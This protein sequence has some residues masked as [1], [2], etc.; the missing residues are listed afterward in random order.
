[1]PYFS[2]IKKSTIAADESRTGAAE[3]SRMEAED[4]TGGMQI[5]ERSYLKSAR[6]VKEGRV[7]IGVSSNS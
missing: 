4:E 3:E 7:A 5:R 1:L 2:P 6:S